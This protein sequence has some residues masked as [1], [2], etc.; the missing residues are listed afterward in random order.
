MR[1]AP[2]APGASREEAAQMDVQRSMVIHRPPAEVFAYA[3]D[4][5]HL[6]EWLAGVAD[7]RQTS[8]GPLGPGAIA[9]LVIRAVGQRVEADCE[10]VAYE[11]GAALALESRAAGVTGSGRL[12]FAPRPDGTE[13]TFAV[14]VQADSPVF[15]LAQGQIAR[16]AGGQLEASLRQLRR[17]VEAAP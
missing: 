15:R 8:P 5:A 6:P 3:A 17:R 2:R 12:T 10:V 4:L 7:A 9:H 14:A 13:L 11:P 1:T 16:I